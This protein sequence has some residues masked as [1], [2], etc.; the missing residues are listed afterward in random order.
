[1]RLLCDHNV[2][3]SYVNTFARTEWITMIEKEDVLPIDSIDPVVIDYAERHDWVV[4][5]SDER[6][7]RDDE[8]EEG[9]VIDA[10]CG[11]VIYHQYERPSPGDVLAALKAI[12]ATYDDYRGMVEYVPSGWIC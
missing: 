11:V 2:A 1:V 12:A 9:R 8:S 4:F 5:T 3:Q 6:F 10:D 7:L